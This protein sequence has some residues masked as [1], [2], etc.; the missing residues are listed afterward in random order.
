[1]VQTLQISLFSEAKAKNKIK[2][3]QTTKNPYL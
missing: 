2:Q 3:K 1:M